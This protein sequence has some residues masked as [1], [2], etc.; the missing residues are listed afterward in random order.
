MSD[1]WEYFFRR[2]KEFE[3]ILGLIRPELDALRPV[4]NPLREHMEALEQFGQ[5][6]ALPTAQ[7]KA[8]KDVQSAL[9]GNPDIRT[10]RE[11]VALE[12]P[13]VQAMQE[14]Q[15]AINK[16]SE[17]L[18]S[19]AGELH[20]AE[21]LAESLAPT[22]ALLRG[23]RLSPPLLE[24]YLEP[25][26]AFL[27]FA[28]AQLDIAATLEGKLSANRALALDATADLLDS[29]RPCLNL[30]S[31]WWAK[32]VA[33]SLGDLPPVNVF[34]S[35]AES[36]GEADLEDEELVVDV[37][38][39]DS[40][41]G[42]ILEAGGQICLL[43]FNI[44][45]EAERNGDG[46][47]FKPTNKG[48]RAASILSSHVASDEHSFGVIID[49]LFFLLYEGSGQAQRL[50]ERVDDAALA[51]LWTLKHLRLS[52]RHDLEHGKE[53]EVRKKNRKV[54][55]AFQRLIG[56]SMPK[57]PAQ[58][59]LAQANLYEQLQVMLQSIWYQDENGPDEP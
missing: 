53:T 14:Q 52:D 25:H 59:A 57:S 5:N 32:I 10:L 37:V 33:P 24:A 27:K 47:V 6:F 2:Q 51:P 17:Q 34:D 39:E 56:A 7:L 41:A 31:D 40:S 30:A 20:L 23:E 50:L 36:L 42:R 28:K 49:H 54:G 35:I 16:I 45:T 48:M 55:D 29:F 9:R 3:R 18:G 46:P 8:L 44:N 43:V 38:V 11:L 26:R 58:W 1:S 19:N 15:A 4:S 13:I 22:E 12:L 21:R